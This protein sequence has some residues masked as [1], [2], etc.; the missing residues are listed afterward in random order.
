LPF[1]GT[2][3]VIEGD[4]VYYTIPKF[5]GLRDQEGKG[6]SF[7]QIKGKVFVAEFFF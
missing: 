7:D 1:F 2:H 5:Y 6:F 4:T 3:D